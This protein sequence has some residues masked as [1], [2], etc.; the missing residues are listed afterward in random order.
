MDIKHIALL[1]NLTLPEDEL[2]KFQEQLSSIL[3]YIEKLQ[4]LD[5]KNIQPTSQITGLGNIVKEDLATPSLNQE[6][7]LSS[8]GKKY[9][10]CFQVEAIF[11]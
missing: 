2:T 7:A 10:G 8:S 9:N 3:D 1:A 5:V 11:K 6:E 4:K